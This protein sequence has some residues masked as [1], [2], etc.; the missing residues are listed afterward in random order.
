VEEQNSS[1][2]LSGRKQGFEHRLIPGLPS[3]LRVDLRPSQAEAGHR[4]V[5]RCDRRFDVGQ[6]QRREPPQSGRVCT[7][8]ASDLF[9]HLTCPVDRRVALHLR[10]KQQRCHRDDLDRCADPVHVCKPLFRRERHPL[11]VRAKSPAAECQE[12]AVGRSIV[13]SAEPFAACI[14]S[15]EQAAWRHMGMKV[16]DR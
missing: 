12:A 11:R 6:R 3:E 10:I 13:G 1:E 9:V 14:G 7:Q 8:P 2:G 16:D 5:E 15:C 4:V